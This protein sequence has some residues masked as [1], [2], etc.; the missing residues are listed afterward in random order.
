MVCSNFWLAAQYCTLAAFMQCLSGS[1][2]HVVNV[3]LWNSSSGLTLVLLKAFLS[4]IAVMRLF[5]LR[6]RASWL[7]ALHSYCASFLISCV[8]WP[9]LL[10]SFGKLWYPPLCTWTALDFS[11]QSPV[12]C[13][14]PA[15]GAL[16]YVG[17]SHCS[18]L[19]L[20]CVRIAQCPAKTWSVLWPWC[21][22]WLVPTAVGFV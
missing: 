12:F 8:T 7:S 14:Q 22:R 19:H 13:A 1:Y 17:P 6:V 4:E 15:T 3:C 20:T 18:A 5:N 9:S 21:P 16:A 2:L 11:T 10:G